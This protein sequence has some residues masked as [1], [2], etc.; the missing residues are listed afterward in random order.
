M[1]KL[2][3]ISLV[4]P[5]LEYGSNI[6]IP[7][8]AIHIYSMEDLGWNPYELPPY[9]SRRTL[10]KLPTTKV[11]DLCRVQHFFWV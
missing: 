10:I 11:I 3:F 2:L 7:C 4:P 8:Y 1:T 6:L 9:H 5:I